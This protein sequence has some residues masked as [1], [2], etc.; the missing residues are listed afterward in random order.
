MSAAQAQP[1]RLRVRAGIPRPKARV[2]LGSAKA[3]ALPLQ[4]ARD[5]EYKPRAVPKPAGLADSAVPRMEQ[6]R[7]FERAA[8]PAHEMLP[9]TR[10]PM[11]AVV[12]PTLRAIAKVDLSPPPEISGATRLRPL[13][14]G[15]P[16]E[17]SL[18]SVAS[19]EFVVRA[20][21]SSRPAVAQRL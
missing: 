6:T 13:S 11:Y 16:W 9:E 4:V 2:S 7:P 14:A 5:Q 20:G 17:A 18:V 1:L 3:T 15:L 12:M 8:Y 21:M 19:L 10:L